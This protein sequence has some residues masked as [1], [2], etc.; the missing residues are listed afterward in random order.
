ML[1]RYVGHA[2]H[3]PSERRK[4]RP[5][6]SLCQHVRVVSDYTNDIQPNRAVISESTAKENQ[7]LQTIP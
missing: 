7:L 1:G 5:V 2:K 3:C 4:L 6:S